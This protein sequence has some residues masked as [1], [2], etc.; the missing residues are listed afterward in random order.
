[1]TSVNLHFSP[2]IMAKTAKCALVSSCSSTEKTME[3]GVRTHRVNVRC[4]A[5]QKTSEMPLFLDLGYP[6]LVLGEPVSK[7]C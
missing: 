1:V 7:M 2:T 3:C 4:S 6:E 5:S